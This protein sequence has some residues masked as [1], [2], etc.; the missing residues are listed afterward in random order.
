MVV[1][2]SMNNHD[3]D[4]TSPPSNPN[5]K[6]DS[7]SDPIGGVGPFVCGIIQVGGSGSL[8]VLSRDECLHLHG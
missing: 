3:S 8:C 7:N 2:E 6:P 1:V 5:S 4:A